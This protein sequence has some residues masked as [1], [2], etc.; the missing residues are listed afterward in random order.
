V[1]SLIVVSD[2]FET[3]RGKERLRW[4]VRVRDHGH[5][6]GAQ[7]LEF[8]CAAVAGAVT[9]YLEHFLV[10][11]FRQGVG[12]RNWFDPPTGGGGQAD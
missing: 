11:G 9:L 2:N 3:R 6:D 8:T 4:N 5:A 12:L 7:G 1:S 10:T